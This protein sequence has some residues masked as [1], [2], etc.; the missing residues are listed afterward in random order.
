MPKTLSPWRD[1]IV[2]TGRQAPSDIVQPSSPVLCT[3]VMYFIIFPTVKLHA[4]HCTVLCLLL[5]MPMYTCTSHMYLVYMP[6]TCTCTISVCPCMYRMC[7]CGRSEH[8]SPDVLQSV[9]L[10]YHKSVL[11]SLTTRGSPKTG[12]I[13]FYQV[14]TK[15]IFWAHPFEN[16]VLGHALK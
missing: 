4:S 12:S 13:N 11:N 16:P 6:C 2:K 1:V 3:T 10:P 8:D 7:M 5:V 15:S 9:L 14:L